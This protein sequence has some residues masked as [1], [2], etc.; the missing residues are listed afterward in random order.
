MERSKPAVHVGAEVVEIVT[1][2]K[3]GKRFFLYLLFASLRTY[4]T[5]Y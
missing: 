3:V 1:T 4:T 2:K 5:F